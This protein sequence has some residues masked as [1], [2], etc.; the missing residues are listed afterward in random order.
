MFVLSSL[1][2]FRTLEGFVKVINRQNTFLSTIGFLS[3]DGLK[4]W[5]HKMIKLLSLEEKHNEKY[6]F[7]W[8]GIDKLQ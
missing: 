8:K 1:I 6:S 2:H 3:R 7:L 5:I 4:L